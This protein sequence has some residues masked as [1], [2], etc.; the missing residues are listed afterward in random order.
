MNKTIAVSCLESVSTP[1]KGSYLNHKDSDISITESSGVF[2]P[3]A[4]QAMGEGS[5]EQLYRKNKKHTNFYYGPRPQKT[6]KKIWDQFDQIWTFKNGH[7]K[8][9]ICIYVIFSKL[10]DFNVL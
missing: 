4:R 10:F 1:A 8:T 6:P 2:T 7:F 5:P 9:Q 3:Q